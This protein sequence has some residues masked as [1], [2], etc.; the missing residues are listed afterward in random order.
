MQILFENFRKLIFA[1]CIVGSTI[2]C[3]TGEDKNDG[4]EDRPQSA[5]G[6]T[7]E[8]NEES[9]TTG[10]APSGDTVAVDP[11]PG[12]IDQVGPTGRTQPK[13]HEETPAY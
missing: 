7:F 12:T 2:S 13:S 6:T 10:T 1:T 3:A 5:V 4:T 8:E 11:Q 9:T